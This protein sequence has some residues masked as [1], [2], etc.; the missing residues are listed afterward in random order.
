MA[1]VLRVFITCDALMPALL[2]AVFFIAL[3]AFM[4]FFAFMALVLRD[5]VAIVAFVVFVVCKVC[6]V[7]RRGCSARARKNIYN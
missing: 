6:K 1:L 2:P 7:A 3:V 4:V 5:F